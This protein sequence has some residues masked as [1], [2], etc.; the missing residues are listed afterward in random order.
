[1]SRVHGA[2]VRLAGLE[3][4][5]GAVRSPVGNLDI[6]CDQFL[7]AVFTPRE[8]NTFISDKWETLRV[9]QASV[10]LGWIWI[11]PQQHDLGYFEVHGSQDVA[12]SITLWYLC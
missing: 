9:S 2:L 8:T 4:R 6:V 11:C 3:E 1:M 12:Q 7:F 10:V 5:R